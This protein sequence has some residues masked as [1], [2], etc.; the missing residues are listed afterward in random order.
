MSARD[1]TERARYEIILDYTCLA[2]ALEVQP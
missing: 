2:A 1:W